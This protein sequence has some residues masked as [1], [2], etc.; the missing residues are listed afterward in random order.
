MF[1]YSTPAAGHFLDPN[2]AQ[3]NNPLPDGLLCLTYDDGPGVTSTP[4]GPGSRTDDL[5]FYLFLQGIPATFFV[6]GQRAANEPQLCLHSGNK[7][8]FF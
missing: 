6:I 8:I 7:A 5:G 1:F 4:T 2:A 3:I